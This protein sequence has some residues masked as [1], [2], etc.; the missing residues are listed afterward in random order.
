MAIPASAQT[1]PPPPQRP[2]ATPATA[3]TPTRPANE[4]AGGYSFLREAGIDGAP[5]NVYSSGWLVSY[6]RRLGES[7]FSIIGEATGNYRNPAGELWQLYAFQGGLRADIWQAG[8]ITFFGQGLAGI[9]MFHVPGFSDQGFS[10]QPG[11]GIDTPLFGP[12]RFRFQADFRWAHYE[13]TN[14]KELRIGASVV[15]GFK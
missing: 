6:G 4:I 9:E 11:G 5:A 1:T 7:R 3:P 10:V 12:A 15:F 14:F 8:S 2:P 13:D